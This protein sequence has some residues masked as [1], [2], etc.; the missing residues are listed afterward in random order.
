MQS[1]ESMS[2]DLNIF[3]VFFC[4]NFVV[5]LGIMLALLNVSSTSSACKR[6]SFNPCCNSIS[7]SS[8][9][10]LNPNLSIKGLIVDAFTNNEKSTMPSV[11]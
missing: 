2:F 5:L 11:I 3:F 8:V 6:D 7:S 9:N 4:I 10:L 1:S